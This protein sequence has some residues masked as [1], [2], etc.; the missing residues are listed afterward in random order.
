MARGDIV[1]EY[2]KDGKFLF[3]Q[4]DVDLLKKLQNGSG[5]NGS[6]YIVDDDILY[7]KLDLNL[8]NSN[9]DLL[10]GK[11]N[12]TFVFPVQSLVVDNIV[13]A[14][15]MRRIYSRNL[16]EL[17]LDVSVDRFI[18]SLD[19]VASDTKLISDDNILIFDLNYGNV[20]FDGEKINVV[21]CDFYTRG[22]DSSDVFVENS[23]MFCNMFH[24]Y[25]AFFDNEEDIYFSFVE[26]H[27]LDEFVNYL[28]YEG[29]FDC[30]KK[31]LSKLKKIVSNYV[32]VEVDNLKE[33]NSVIKRYR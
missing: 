29:D 24:N 8:C 17:S 3:D 30:L 6:C 10:T 22:F 2:F 31:Y 11:D 7:K 18:K 15:I 4:V 16:R 28:I 25:V 9:F 23:N 33:I 19:K 20:L 21:D 13:K 12:D 5:K 14:Y 32:G 27:K 26:D 1:Q